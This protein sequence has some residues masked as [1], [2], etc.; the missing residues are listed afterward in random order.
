MISRELKALYYAGMKVPMLVNGI[1]YKLFRAPRTGIV[2]VQLGPGQKNYLEG[3]INLDANIFTARCDVWANLADTLPFRDGTVDVF[4]SHHVIEHLPDRHLLPHFGDMYRCLKA[5]GMI[6][7]GGPNGD[8]AIGKFIAGDSKWFGDFPDAHRSIGG[9]LVNFVFCRNEH[10]TLLTASYLDE[11]ATDSG[12]KNIQ[13]CIPGKTTSN[14]NYIDS[15]V[16]EMEAWSPPED[17]HTLLI[18]AYK[19]KA[20]G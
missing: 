1:V 11:I 9:K 10:L 7:V 18:E 4:Y 2:K 8:T 6:R 5:G 13:V 12:F 16:L 19:P 3:W 15:A 17:P 20:T 14:P